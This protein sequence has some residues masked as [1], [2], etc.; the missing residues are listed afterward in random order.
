MEVFTRCP[1][2][3]PKVRK[4]IRRDLQSVEI[5]VVERCRSWL[6]EARRIA[7]HS[8]WEFKGRIG[9]STDTGIAQ[10]RVSLYNWHWRSSVRNGRSIISGP[11]YGIHKRWRRQIEGGIGETRL[12]IEDHNCGQTQVL[13]HKAGVSLRGMGAQKHSP[14][15]KETECLVRS[16]HDDLLTM[17]NLADTH[18]WLAGWRLSLSNFE[19]KVTY[20]PGLIVQVPKELCL[21]RPEDREDCADS[22]VGIRSLHFS[23][24]PW[25]KRKRNLHKTRR[26]PTMIT[27]MKM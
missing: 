16:N 23:R 22:E 24:S 12:W 17:L 14:Y 15:M 5:D 13:N 21:C 9:Q 18:G 6:G 1:Q 20:W 11:G 10:A 19:T 27:W 8:S 7:E 4:R 26:T 2:F 3:I 25:K